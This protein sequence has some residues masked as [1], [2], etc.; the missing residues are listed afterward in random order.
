[1]P[2][3]DA[4]T[5]R[6]A[7]SNT[8]A[9]ELNKEKRRKRTEIEKKSR[10]DAKR[11]KLDP[12][13]QWG[14]YNPDFPT[15]GKA[16]ELELH[17][18]LGRLEKISRFAES[19]TNATALLLSQ[20][21]KSPKLEILSQLQ[22]KL[23]HFPQ[24]DVIL[25]T[26]AKSLETCL[27]QPFGVP[28][29]HR[30]TPNYPSLGSYTQFGI[31]DFL[32]HLA[33]DEEASISVYDYSIEDPSQRTRR[34]TVGELLSCFWSGN[35]RGTALNFLD[36]ENRTRIEFCPYQVILRNI[37]TRIDARK[38]RDKGKT[39]SEWTAEP[40]KEFFLLSLEN[41][42]STIH[43]DTGGVV[44]WVLILEGRKIWYFPRHVTAQTVRW[45]SFAGSQ[46]PEDYR[47]GWVKV[48]LRPG[49]LLIMPPSF[50]HA[51][52]TP[53]KCLAVGGQSYT[54]GNLGR[55]IEGLKLQEDHPDISNEDLDDSVYSTLARILNECGPVTTYFEKAQVASG[56][57]LF[58]SL[59]DP[60]TYDKLSKNSLAD[61]LR[62]GG[63]AIPSKAKKIE[64]LELLKKNSDTR[65]ACTPR[66]EFLEAFRKFCDEFMADGI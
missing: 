54:A 47:D 57:S 12:V 52:Y 28:L 59:R 8:R 29:L 34:T 58:P 40:R 62:S 5:A 7:E 17:D 16:G 3:N 10:Q 1:M 39:G 55:S 46:T 30:A 50:P 9:E 35:V 49:D 38:Q 19:R 61:I 6:A 43:V 31:Q 48:E 24:D 51:V 4:N 20:L 65:A 41:A 36:I 33:E 14:K 21:R 42:I 53:E 66:E 56:Q 15:S 45:L 32:K 22:S 25:L 64:L 37:T 60:T 18:F 2:T 13:I 44:T 27:N 26:D 23:P 63:V 11:C